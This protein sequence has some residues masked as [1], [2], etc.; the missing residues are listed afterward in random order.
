M[1]IG[2]VKDYLDLFFSAEPDFLKIRNL[3]AGSFTFS[4]PL[5]KATS[6]DDYISK[7]NDLTN[8]MLSMKNVEFIAQENQIAVIYDM[9]SPLGEVRTVEWFKVKDS[10]IQSLELLNDPRVFVEAFSS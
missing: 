6:A 7:L 10:K 2:I 8:G 9:V 5:L 1:S 3:L 4:G